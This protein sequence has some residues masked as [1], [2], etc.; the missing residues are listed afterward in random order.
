[1]AECVGCNKVHDFQDEANF[2]DYPIC[3]EC[4]EMW[5]MW[6]QYPNMNEPKSKL[7][8]SAFSY[9][10]TIETRPL[11]IML[12]LEVWKKLLAMKHDFFTDLSVSEED[13]RD[14]LMEALI[15]LAPLTVLEAWCELGDYFFKQGRDGFNNGRFEYNGKPF[16]TE[17]AYIIKNKDNFKGYNA[18]SFTPPSSAV[19]NAKKGLEM[20]K[21]WGRGGLTPAEAKSQGIDSG[22]T[23]ARK[24]ASGKVSKHDVKRMSAFNR[25][26][27]NY[28]PS[29]KK[30]D[31]GPTA[32][33]IAW[34][35]WGGTS[36]VNWAKKKSKTLAA[37]GEEESIY[38]ILKS[39]DVEKNIQMGL[40]T[41][42]WLELIDTLEEMIPM[43]KIEGQQNIYDVLRSFTIQLL[44]QMNQSDWIMIINNL[45]E[46]FNNIE[47]EV[48]DSMEVICSKCGHTNFWYHSYACASMCSNNCGNQVDN[49][50]H[51]PY[52]IDNYCYY[53]EMCEQCDK[54][55]QVGAVIWDYGDDI[56]PTPLCMDCFYTSNEG[57]KK[58]GFGGYINGDDFK[59]DVKYEL[60]PWVKEKIIKK[61]FSDSFI[62]DYQAESD[63]ATLKKYEKTYGKKGAK[64]RLDLKNKIMKQ[65]THG[66]KSG[67]W[68]ARK[69]QKLKKDY[70]RAMEKKR[71]KPYK[72]SKKTESQKDLKEW[73]DQDWKTKSGKKSSVT[74]ERYLPS[75][76]IDALTNEEYKRT[77]A[78]KKKAKKAGKQFSKQP[79]DI[80]KKVAKYRAEEELPFGVCV[81]HHKTTST[82]YYRRKP[83][84]KFKGNRHK[85]Q[86]V[87][88]AEYM[89]NKLKDNPNRFNY[90]SYRAEYTPEQEIQ[91]YSIDQLMKSSA[92]EGDF[93]QDSL[94]YSVVENLQAEDDYWAGS[95]AKEIIKEMGD[96]YYF[97]EEMDEYDCMHFANEMS[98]WLNID[99]IKNEIQT[100]DES[101]TIAHA[102]VYVP[103]EKLYY[104]AWT[105][106]GVSDWKKLNYW[107]FENEQNPTLPHRFEAEDSK[108]KDKPPNGWKIISF[109]DEKNTNYQLQ[110]IVKCKSFEEV[111]SLIKTINQ[112]ADEL[113]HHPLVKYQFNSVVIN[114]W[115][116]D[117]NS[118][119]DLDFKFANQ[120]NDFLD[121]TSRMEGVSFDGEQYPLDIQFNQLQ[122][123]IGRPIPWKVDYGDGFG[124]DVFIGVKV[125]KGGIDDYDGWVLVDEWNNRYMG[126]DTAMAWSQAGFE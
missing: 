19:A 124:D 118:L 119:T 21:K 65:N 40:S 13:K 29:V 45:E 61:G 81:V 114:L 33:T 90:M 108:K 48:D 86:A 110:R 97:D 95:V 58:K 99:G 85:Q 113:N 56:E 70:E 67:Q 103:H 5:D 32:G 44:K 57:F 47:D 116:H 41:P 30:P 68:S 17:K 64:V 125:V 83:F 63:T 3:I 22:I 106:F 60:L 31:G 54:N 15:E 73:G 36:G 96:D 80:A 23:R 9:L 102:W 7:F 87:S 50:K 34:L 122:N 78:A 42:Q 51:E 115:T 123:Y 117:T 98:S 2:E 10:N 26:R 24:I 59:G 35:L 6:G 104:D 79:K 4:Q 16:F 55:N 100:L 88:Y 14:I 72:S 75:K 38:D 27:K 28:R 120:I 112:I 12:G 25:H 89:A 37:E 1:M 109:Y 111:K 62:E 94:K 101:P 49:P 18:E 92:V 53:D 43:P 39:F 76:A 84:R 74:G 82:V 93:T 71:L 46:S 66:T 91:D 11:I 69:S 107:D 105:P 20:R 8:E 126:L 77:S 121:A 52:H